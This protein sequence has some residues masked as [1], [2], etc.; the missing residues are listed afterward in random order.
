MVACLCGDG[1]L[2][3]DTTCE[4]GKC[5]D[6]QTVCDDRCDGFDGVQGF[7]ASDNDEVAIPSCDSFCQRLSING[8]ELGCD[9]VFS[10]CLTPSS[11]G[12]VVGLWDCIVNEAVITCDD[13]TVRIEGCDASTLGLC[14]I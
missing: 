7:A 11:C 10:A 2:A 9:T 6:E 13:N 4:L 5:L 8:C 1:S 12:S 3:L 14:Q